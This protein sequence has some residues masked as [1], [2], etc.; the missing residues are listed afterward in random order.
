MLITFGYGDL[1]GVSEATV[2][3]RIG[4]L[5]ASGFIA[6]VGSNKNG[7]WEVLK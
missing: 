4:E 3:R 7:H 5:K 2:K 1:L 6:R